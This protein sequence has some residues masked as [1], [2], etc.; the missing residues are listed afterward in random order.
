MG[1][2]PTEVQLPWKV[3]VSESTVH[4]SATWHDV[5]LPTMQTADAMAD[6]SEAVMNARRLIRNREMLEF[7]V[8]SYVTRTGL[9]PLD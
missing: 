4:S 1:T 6:T 5:E 9:T 7:R 3:I 2:P 8:T